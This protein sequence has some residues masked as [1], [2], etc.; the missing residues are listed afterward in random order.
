MEDFED[1]G[2]EV[3]RNVKECELGVKIENKGP[4]S[5][6]TGFFD[7][8]TLYSNP[9]TKNNDSVCSGVIGNYPYDLYYELFQPPHK[10]IKCWEIENFLSGCNGPAVNEIN[11]GFYIYK[12]KLMDH[13]L[14][15]WVE[16]LFSKSNTVKIINKFQKSEECWNYLHLIYNKF[17]A[18]VSDPNSNYIKH[19]PKV[20]TKNYYN[21]HQIQYKSKISFKPYERINQFQ[22]ACFI[23]GNSVFEQ[24]I[25]LNS[26]MGHLSSMKQCYNS[27]VEKASNLNVCN[28]EIVWKNF[29]SQVIEM[30]CTNGNLGVLVFLSSKTKCHN[31]VIELELAD[32]TVME[33]DYLVS[34]ISAIVK[35]KVYFI[36]EVGAGIKGNGEYCIKKPK[37]VEFV[38]SF[39]CGTNTFKGNQRHFSKLLE[40][41]GEEILT[42]DELEKKIG[43]CLHKSEE[44]DFVIL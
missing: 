14:K 29:L 26:V 9:E 42:M 24:E 30:Y 40:L 8:F 20:S 11:L 33:L 1:R 16:Y 44:D 4:H 36:I 6:G 7:S 34:S 25:G 43:T 22:K 38:F 18:I 32:H 13:Q 3:N 21:L 2:D 15:Y 35:G 5:E 28:F 27:I 12:V 23:H 37:N 17:Q 31:G 41:V 39:N 10:L 19:F